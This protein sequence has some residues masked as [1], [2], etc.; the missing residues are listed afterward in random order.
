MKT[1]GDYD[2]IVIGGGASG[3]FSAI[4]AAQKG[5]NVLIL[6]KNDRLGN[7]LS[8]TGGGRC[9]ITNAETDTHTFLKNFGD[10][11]KFLYSPYSQFSNADTCNFFEKN[12][13]PIVVE[14]RKR[15]FPKTQSAESVR[16]L[17]EN[18][19]KEA[20]V[21]IHTKTGVLGFRHKDG[22]I[23]G[24]ETNSGIY[25]A[26][27]YIL[28][29]GGMS[30]PETGST[31]D[32]FKWLAELGHSVSAP[33]PSIVPL[34]V[35]ESWVHKISG[36]SLSFM[37]ITFFVKNGNSLIKKFY[38]KGKILFTHFGISGPLILNSATR[39]ADIL[40]EGAV[41][42]AIDMY[43]DTDE[44]ALEAKLLNIFDTNKN[45]LFKNVIDECVPHGLSQTIL[46]LEIIEPETKVHSISREQRKTLV[47]KL[48]AMPMTITGLMGYEKAVVADGGVPL[49]EVDTKTMR[50]K[51][52]SNLFITGDLLHINRPSG[53]YSLQ[54]CWTTGY[55]AGISA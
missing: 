54:L 48:K 21:T 9:N 55:V 28:A 46:D 32:G 34:K 24:V 37:K 10:K 19:L 33:T 43:P 29:T 52:I 23:T 40:H 16:T 18:L 4:H 45:K 31:G 15:A 5:K 47:S 25:S 22:V 50:S 14:A 7:K 20:G 49:E 42:A 38:K 30:H 27:N 3:M 44:G 26:T 6:E 51:I 41:V 11:A 1:S 53:G 35:K 13:M 17:F 8:I 36:T 2:V 12:K 39:V